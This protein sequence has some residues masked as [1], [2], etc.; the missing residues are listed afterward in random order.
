MAWWGRRA[1]FLVRW[2][3]AVIVAVAVPIVVLNKVVIGDG[4]STWPILIYFA[5]LPGLVPVL[6]IRVA[7]SRTRPS[8]DGRGSSRG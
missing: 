8:F 4:G 5:C 2:E 3:W 1:G 7:R 6:L